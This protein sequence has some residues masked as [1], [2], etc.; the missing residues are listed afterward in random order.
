MMLTQHDLQFDYLFTFFGS[1]STL[2]GIFGKLHPENKAAMD[3]LHHKSWAPHELSNGWGE[4]FIAHLVLAS[5]DI[6]SEL[7]LL[8]AYPLSANAPS[9]VF[10]GTLSFQLFRDKLLSHFATRK[11]LVMLDDATYALVIFGCRV[12]TSN[13]LQL[14]IG[15]PHIATNQTCPFTGIYEIV[16]DAKGKQITASLSE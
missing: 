7:L 14:L 6:K 11:G 8:N 2:L 16:V 10:E 13:N 1:K 5:Y 12:D 15:D 4:P 9:E 3:Q